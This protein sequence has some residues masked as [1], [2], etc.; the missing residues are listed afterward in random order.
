MKYNLMQIVV[1][2]MFVITLIYAIRQIII[3][4]ISNYNP[5]ILGTFIL[6]ALISAVGIII[7]IEEKD[8]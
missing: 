8:W 3:H 4:A 5:I 7:C 6:M 1:I 2:T